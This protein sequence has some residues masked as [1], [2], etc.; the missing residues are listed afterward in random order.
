M[1]G[2]KACLLAH[3]GMISAG[4]DLEEAM[5]VCIEVESLCEQYWRALQIAEPAHL[6]PAQM[7]EV[8]ERFKSYG[9]NDRRKAD[10][11]SDR[12]TP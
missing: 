5:A 12:D 3:H 10:R 6:S 4:A 9:R 7:D 11:H 1:D 8:I 2:R